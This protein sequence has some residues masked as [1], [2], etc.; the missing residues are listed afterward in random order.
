MK[1][2]VGDKV[3]V[4][5]DLITKKN[6]NGIEFTESMK[7]YRGM[8]G[9]I[10]WVFISEEEGKPKIVSYYMKGLAHR[11]T[12]DMLELVDTPTKAPS[13]FTKADLK[14]KMVVETRNGER[15]LVVDD[16]LMNYDG[17]Q[18]IDTYNDDLTIDTNSM[19]IEKVY[20]YID[21]Y[22]HNCV[23]LKYMLSSR[24]LSLIWGRPQL[25][26]ITKAELA[27]MGYELEDK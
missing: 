18:P 5:M 25:K 9:K 10:E 27:K 23:A 14:T 8:E 22:E 19:I 15:Y 21:D 26:P 24:N 1:F 17:F 2:K 13:Q 12:D 6:Y 7:P 16:I 11:Y 20:K 4:K 3:R